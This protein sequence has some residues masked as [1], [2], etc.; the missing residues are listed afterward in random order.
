MTPNT[1]PDAFADL[2]SWMEWSLPTMGE[3][4]AQRQACSISDLEAFYHAMLPRMADVLDFLA[5]MAPDDAPAEA[6][7]LLHLAHSFAE[8]APA[9][10][11][12]GQPAVSYGYDVARFI[13]GPEWAR[14]PSGQ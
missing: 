7:A 6:M 5:E 14:E 1:L 9:V 12:F 8:V 10:E 11:C 4:S 3:R 13:P 2:G